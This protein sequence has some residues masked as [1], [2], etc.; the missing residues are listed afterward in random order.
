MYR[1]IVKFSVLIASV[2]IVFSSCSKDEDNTLDNNSID[3]GIPPIADFTTN[4]TKINTG[5]EIS[6]TDQSTNDP[7]SWNWDFGDGGSSSEQNPSHSYD[8][9]GTYTVSLTVTS[10]FGNDTET[11]T[12]YITVSTTLEYGSVTDYDGN[13]YK[14]VTIGSQIW[15]AENLR[16]THYPDGTEI[17]LEK[18]YDS[19]ADLDLSDDAYCYYLNGAGVGSTFISK[20]GALYTYAAAEDA[21]PTGW[22]LPSDDEWKTLEMYMGMSQSEANISGNGRGT[23]EGKKLKAS[24]YG[25]R[26]KDGTDDYGFSAYG[27]GSRGY[28]SGLFYY[29]Y[30][31]GNWWT[32]TDASTG[33]A[34]IRQLYYTSDNINRFPTPYGTGL[35]VRCIKD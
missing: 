8:T 21:C 17:P 27:G 33:Q 10:S 18:G 13:T 4:Q 31:A 1:K 24:D 22:H 32:S 6:F 29:D 26:I 11:K 15:M 12:D 9:Q 5:E 7:S 19:W 16:S 20:M 14:T 34:F 3:T 30:E 23:G 25:W 35:S 28:D 2:V